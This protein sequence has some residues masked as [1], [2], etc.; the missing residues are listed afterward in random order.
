MN[1]GRDGTL[2]TI[3]ASGAEGDLRRIAALA[4]RA[5][6]QM[7]MRDAEEEVR[8]AIG[9]VVHLARENGRRLIKQVVCLG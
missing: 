8:S 6:G 5:S 1:T 4:V 2:T 9:I 3:H 7:T